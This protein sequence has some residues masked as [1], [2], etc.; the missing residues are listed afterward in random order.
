MTISRLIILRMRNVSNKRCRE[1][2][3]SIL[4]SVR[5]FWKS[6]SLLDNVEIQC[7]SN[8]TGTNCD[9]FTH[10]QSRSYLNHLVY[11]GVGE[12]ASKTKWWR[13]AYWISNA[14]RAST[15]PRPCTHTH[16]STRTHS[17]TRTHTHTEMCNTYSFSTA[18]VVSWTRRSVALY[19]HCL[20]YS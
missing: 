1:N 20:V 4:Y 19:V 17:P 13:A 5:F 9:L 12:A 7:S 3:T 8:M 6:C 16:T 10:N 15:S 14:T 18:E 2:Q 11:S